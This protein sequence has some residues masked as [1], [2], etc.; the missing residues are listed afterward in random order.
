MF[1]IPPIPSP[2]PAIAFDISRAIARVDVFDSQIYRGGKTVTYPEFVL[3]THS[4]PFDGL[5]AA[6]QFTGENP[7]QKLGILDDRVLNEHRFGQVQGLQ[8]IVHFP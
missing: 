7:T 4:L 2:P 1:S 6:A 3:S 5:K 8:L